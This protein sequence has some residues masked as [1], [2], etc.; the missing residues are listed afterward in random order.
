MLNYWLE[1]D[2]EDHGSVQNLSHILKERRLAV[3]L[4][5]HSFEQIG[6]FSLE[7]RSENHM[8]FMQ[9]KPCSSVPHYSP[10][11]VSS[12]RHVLTLSALGKH[13]RQPCLQERPNRPP[14][15][16]TLIF[17]FMLTQAL[18]IRSDNIVIYFVA[19]EVVF[20]GSL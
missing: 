14:A 12:H 9:R 7:A 6:F 10:C 1:G 15:S 5:L 4:Y 11:P 16:F 3:D 18:R 17:L 19:S 20:A 13:G 8:A 2:Q